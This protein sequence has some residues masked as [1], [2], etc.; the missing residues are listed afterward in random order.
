MPWAQTRAKELFRCINVPVDGSEVYDHVKVKLKKDEIDGEMVVMNR[1]GK[2]IYI[3]DFSLSF[4]WEAVPRS[5]KSPP[6]S[7][8]PKGSLK[9][10][11][12]RSTPPHRPDPQALPPP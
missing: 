2:L 3:F 1:K 12:V 11:V 10:R 9:V 6:A 4:T 7:E 5:D 8:R